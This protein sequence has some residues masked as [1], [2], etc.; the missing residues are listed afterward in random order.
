MSARLLIVTQ[1]N[2]YVVLA[3]V[4]ECQREMLCLLL[5][6]GN[7]SGSRVDQVQSNITEGAA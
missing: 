1:F 7:L 5:L 4:R 2:F 3:W 6:I